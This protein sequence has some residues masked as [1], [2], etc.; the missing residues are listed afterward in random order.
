LPVLLSASGCIKQMLIDGQIEGT[1]QGSVAFDRFGDFE[2]GEMAAA[3]A[4]L[5]FEGML[6]L[7]PGNEDALFLLTKGYTGFAYAFIEDRMETA[8]DA[9]DRAGAE[10]HRKR[11]KT[12]YQHAIRYGLQLLGQEADGFE[13]AKKT[14]ETLKAWVTRSFTDPEDAADLFWTGYA[15]VSHANLSRDD[16]EVI[17]NLYIGVALV[18]RSV[19]LD[20]TYNAHSAEIVLGAYH[21]RTATA[22]LDQA[23][24]LFDKV[25]AATG[26]K[27]LLA[28]TL[29]ATSY[30]CAK[31]DP[32]GYDKLLREVLAAEDPDPTQR[33]SNMVAQRRAARWLGE[34]RMFD[35]CSMDPVAPP[36]PAPAT[37]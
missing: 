9:G 37:N 26:R 15:W 29:Y 30:F 13:E 28:Q 11:A 17:A 3:S 25:L 24:V 20:P 19:E 33:L 8:D 34:K 2:A 5:Q 35:A 21:A 16:A 18:E 23:Q 12:A 31:S 32:A 36:E 27:F 22:E 10:Y 14:P 7:S 1:R 4:V 6:E